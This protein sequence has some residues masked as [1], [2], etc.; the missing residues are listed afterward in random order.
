MNIVSKMKTKYNPKDT[1]EDK[2]DSSVA[3]LAKF[4]SHTEEQIFSRHNKCHCY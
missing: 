1:L 2:F 3:H 4:T